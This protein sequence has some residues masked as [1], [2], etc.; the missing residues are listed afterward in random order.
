MAA[1]PPFKA[2]GTPRRKRGRGRNPSPGTPRASARARAV[3]SPNARF[4]RGAAKPTNTSRKG[5]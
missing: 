1:F 3:A 5:Y 2:L 4:N